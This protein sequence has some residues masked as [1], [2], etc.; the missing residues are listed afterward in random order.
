VPG[1][2]PPRIALRRLG[3]GHLFGALKTR[4]H[5]PALRVSL[6]KRPRAFGLITVEARQVLQ[7]LIYAPRHV[8][9]PPF[10]AAWA[11]AFA[12]T[13]ARR[14]IS[15]SCSLAASSVEWALNNTL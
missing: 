10:C 11:L 5:G 1:V 14:A 8:L 4:C 7:T 13:S 12:S 3:C 15:S 9:P 6:L 2:A